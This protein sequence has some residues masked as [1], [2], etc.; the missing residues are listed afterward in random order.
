MAG[1]IAPFPGSHTPR[2]PLHDCTGMHG[3]ALTAG[4]SAR[5]DSLPVFATVLGAKSNAELQLQFACDS[6]LANPQGLSP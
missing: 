3:P 4:S 1:N 6:F 5:P 2:L